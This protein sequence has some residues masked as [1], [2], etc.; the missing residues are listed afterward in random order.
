MPFSAASIGSQM[1]EQ[2]SRAA[3]QFE[4]SVCQLLGDWIYNNNNSSAVASTLPLT[5]SE[6]E[7]FLLHAR[8]RSGQ[9]LRLDWYLSARMCLLEWLHAAAARQ[10]GT[11]QVMAVEE[12]SPRHQTPQLRHNNQPGSSR[13]PELTCHSVL[14]RHHCEDLASAQTEHPRSSSS[15]RRQMF[16]RVS[17]YLVHITHAHCDCSR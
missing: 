8:T 15:Q 14:R 5:C 9:L 1:I 2:A 16:I 4:D 13:C 12:Q 17:Q 6:E 10:A 3:S 11:I 7:L